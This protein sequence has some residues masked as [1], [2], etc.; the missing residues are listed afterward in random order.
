[1]TGAPP[2]P[3]DHRDALEAVQR[4]FADGLPARVTVLRRALGRVSQGATRDALEAFH[5]PAHALKGTAESF[6]AGELAA[7]AGDLAALGRR[8]LDHGP[9]PGEL[10]AAERAIDGLATAIE[11]YRQRIAAP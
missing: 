1:V 5:L 8:W 2:P 10:D 11:R 6:G 4:E 3:G 7:P 9:A